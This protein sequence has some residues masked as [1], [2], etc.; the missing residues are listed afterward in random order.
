MWRVGNNQWEGRNPLLFL[1]VYRG[2]SLVV[3]VALIFPGG[4]RYSISGAE[5][6]LLVVL[7]LYTIFKLI[8]PLY[9]YR[10]DSH[11]IYMYVD[12]GVDLLLAILVLLFTG[13]L[14]SP[15]ILYSLSPLLSSAI[16]F[17]RKITFPI[18]GLPALAAI[19]AE[20]LLK[21]TDPEMVF[22]PQGALFGMLCA[23]VVG[24]FLLAWLPY[25]MNINVSQDIRVR[26]ISEERRRLS[27]DMHDG[28]AQTLGIVRWRV[29]LLQK[30]IAEGNVTQAIKDAAEIKAM[31]EGA[32]RETR[33]VI[34][35]LRTTIGDSQ[36]FVPT[37]AQYA[38]EF[39][40]NYGIK[41]ELRMA[42]GE[43]SL[44]TLAE[45][46]LLY[47]AQEALTNVR[48]HAAASRVEL[49]FKTR[50][51]TAEM[52]ISDNGRGFDPAGRSQ[53][54][55][56]AVMRERIKS[57]GGELT[58]NSSPGRGTEIRVRLAALR[59]TWL[60]SRETRKEKR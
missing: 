47:V 45:V 22:L 24:S 18:A 1:A 55:G 46:E 31:V 34:D 27:R 54:Y 60:G 4:Y 28:V 7:A 29:E 33:E 40:Q 21:R 51:D 11:N 36:G 14:R 56:M 10:R 26:A 48:K 59:R 23:S 49:S 25:V 17:S 6:G 20:L 5:W 39:T 42:D 2:F 43:V 12:F 44:P 9:Q 3:A 13:G 52:V 15:F 53:G 58:V 50:G 38:T 41:C 8:H 37:L 16:L 32:Q 57:I 30:T 19:T 35:Q